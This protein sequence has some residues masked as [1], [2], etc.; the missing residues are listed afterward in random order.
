[1]TRIGYQGAEHKRING[2]PAKMAPVSTAKEDS[3]LLLSNAPFAQNAGKFLSVP[4]ELG[5]SE[6]G[7]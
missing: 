5:H 7:K 4:E 6:N 1:V 3:N 2:M